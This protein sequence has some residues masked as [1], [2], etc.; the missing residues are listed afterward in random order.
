[1]T[2]ECCKRFCGS[3]R[4]S[5]MSPGRA[6]GIRAI[7]NLYAVPAQHYLSSIVVPLSSTSLPVSLSL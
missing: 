2:P 7:M 3:G 6:C 5:T 4:Y 1:M